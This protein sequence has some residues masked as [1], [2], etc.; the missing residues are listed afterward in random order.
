MNKLGSKFILLKN[1]K[2]KKTVCIL[3]IMQV[4]AGYIA[5]TNSS[6]QKTAI[7]NYTKTAP[8]IDGFPDEPWDK[9]AVQ[10][11]NVP[12]KNDA[13]TI[14]TSTWQGLY[15][16]KNFYCVV[17]C[18]DDDHWPSWESGGNSWEYDKPEFYWDVNAVL[19]DGIGAGTSNSGHYQFAPGFL[20]DSYDTPITQQQSSIGSLNPGGTFAYSLIG[21]GYVY[22]I[23]IPWSSFMDENDNPT[24]P[25]V[26]KSRQ[27]G[28][29]I[30]V[31]DQ[32]EGVT[33]WRQRESWSNSGSVDE[34]WN[35]MDGAGIIFLQNPTSIQV[36]DTSKI[37][38]GYGGTESITVTTDITWSASS[39]QSWLTV[40]PSSKNGSG[41]ITL[42][43]TSNPTNTSRNALVTISGL[44][45]ISKTIT[46]TQLGGNTKYAQINYTKNAPLI[47]GT[48]ES[49]WDQVASVE[50]I[51]VNFKNEVPTI[52]NSTWRGLY[53]NDNFY[54]VVF[55]DDDDHWPSW[56]S[57]GDSWAYDQPEFYW[58][59]NK[60]LKDGLGT[61]ASSTGHYRLAPGFTEYSYDTQISIPQSDRGN[62][63]PGGTWAYSLERQGY[64]YEI[65]VPW[66]ALTDKNNQPTGPAVL[67]TRQI[68]FDVTIVDQD[69]GI[70]MYRQ[71]ANWNNAG[72]IDEAW[73]NM[74][75]AGI[76]TLQKIAPFIQLSD[77]VKT[78]DYSGGSVA[79]IKVSSNTSWS[80]SSDKSW[81]TVTPATNTG[82][83]TL[84][85]TAEENSTFIAR[86]AIVTVWTSDLSPRSIT[87][88]QNAG[89]A[90]LSVSA[91]KVTV[92]KEE[93]SSATIFITSNLIWTSSSDQSWLIVTPSMHQGNGE[94]TVTALSAN[95]GSTTR[96]ATVTITATGVS[97]KNITVKQEVGT[98]LSIST[99]AV[100]LANT[101]SSKTSVDVLSN[102]NWNT[103]SDQ[104]WLTVTPASGAGNGTISLMA[105][106]NMSLT[107]RTAIVTISSGGK[108]LQTIV[109]T[110]A[111]GDPIL[112]PASTSI[113][114]TATE[115]SLASVEITSNIN[116]IASSNQ[117]WL[118]VFPGSEVSGNCTLTFIAS[119][120]P[121]I[122]TR[123]ATVTLTSIYTTK[124]ITV[125]QA[126]GTDGVATLA[127]SSVN[128]Y[129][130]PVKNEFRIRGVEDYI[131]VNIT[132]LDGR[133]VLVKQISGSDPISIGSL[134]KGIY[135][136]KIITSTGIIKKKLVKE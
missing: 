63:N 133:I 108:P 135:I 114:I 49:I 81:L 40:S 131:L 85:F 127:A 53:D 89:V 126:A 27:I 8:I 48:I 61:N 69:H 128:L 105:S 15:D 78:V 50:K 102:T 57:G 5:P 38:S 129:P 83:A 80:A 121:T 45:A 35:N 58:D 60:I 29:D 103:S 11:I 123:T 41:T 101:D 74:D 67:G 134:P 12:F 79:S 64:I 75:D 17:F 39:N 16:D 87:I 96:S 62:P 77:T 14:G 30:T 93:S 66:S 55:C 71:R 31:A 112:I 32:D 52:G 36:S 68:G 91:N 73:N 97:S 54:C 65:A 18:D 124:T 132:D 72:N 92:A 122:S 19:K 117:V 34:N 1:L 10:L 47:D 21:E 110:Q 90:T 9:A 104:T 107:T 115:G 2:M 100:S 82:N 136:V 7:I 88:K 109:V 46:V 28:F 6:A 33:L 70:T 59:V 113:T 111:A 106:A 98:I 84:T 13:P 23:A 118:T 43:A 22:E 56:E 130:N 86:T 24:G 44:D 76:I 42:T 26:L 37:I 120:N 119:H 3:I 4:L 125:T 99:N 25:N 51:D 94:L 95:K 116:W 20:E